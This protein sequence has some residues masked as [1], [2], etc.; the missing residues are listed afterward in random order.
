M[1]FSEI[2]GQQHLKSHL[3]KTAATGRVAHAQLFEGKMGSGILPIAIAYA[4]ELLCL[5]YE[6]DSRA[7][8][9]C[10]EKVSQLEHP[11]LHFVYPV[12]KRKGQ[13]DGAVSDDYAQEWREFVLKNPYGSL[14]EWVQF[15][16]LGNSQAIINV[17]EAAKISN[18]LSLKSYEGG[19]KVMIIWMAEGMN[20]DCANKILKIIEEPL[21]KTVLLLLTERPD[22]ILTTI[23][24]RCQKL[25]FPNLT[26]HEIAEG[27]MRNPEISESQAH[28]IAI[29]AQGDFNKALQIASQSGDEILFEKWFVSWV[30]TAFSA[31]G[32]KS[33]INQI[34]AWSDE[35]SGHTRE[36]HKKF[37]TFCLELFRQSLLEN[38]KTPSLV[39]YTPNDRSFKLENF[40]PFV[41]QNNIFEISKALEDAIYHVE[42]NANPKLLFT[43]LSLHLTRLIHTKS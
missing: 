43:D 3:E 2:I 35:V 39:Y 26:E 20:T 15:I 22:K 9:I 1:T 13:R 41:H 16:E 7:Y 6:K 37:L 29:Q 25:T 8:R 18:K 36:K 17:H 27:L 34:L 5:P 32:N 28:Q 12:N 30:R 19:Y 11:D 31:R 24:S 14:Q 23:Q 4:S 10:Q 38:Y 21:D 33:A 42:R 40:A